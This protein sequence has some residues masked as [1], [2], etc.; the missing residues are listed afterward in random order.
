M[1]TKQRADLVRA[2]RLEMKRAGGNRSKL[3]ETG[4]RNTARAN[5]WHQIGTEDE[6][7]Q[8]DIGLPVGRAS[9]LARSIVRR[10]Q[11]SDLEMRRKRRRYTHVGNRHP[12]GGRG[13]WVPE[14]SGRWD[15]SGRDARWVTN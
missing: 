6:Q 1:D 15:R 4:R 8:R 12:L 13:R 3:D 9:P 10:S 11:E 14:G 2:Y 5:A 7:A